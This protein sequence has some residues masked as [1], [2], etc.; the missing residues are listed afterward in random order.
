[1]SEEKN[2][3]QVTE[4]PV[5]EPAPKTSRKNIFPFAVG[6]AVLILLVLVVMG[7]LNSQKL[8]KEVV[9]V[10]RQVEA[11]K[12][13]G[14]KTDG[15]LQALTD[16]LAVRALQQRRNRIRRALRALDDLQPAVAANPALAAK[17]KGLRKALKKEGKKLAQEIGSGHPVAAFSRPCLSGQPCPPGPC[18]CPQAA[19]A[20][21]TRPAAPGHLECANGVCRLVPEKPAADKAYTVALPEGQPAHPAPAV[22]KPES[23]GSQAESSA[24]PAQPE[25][26]WTRFINLRIFGGN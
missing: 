22:A 12:E 25:T 11:L 24:S 4:S 15:R 16:E 26:W 5:S 17:V 13:N 21:K 14:R 8:H 19:A 18:P 23:A 6:L 2:E 1:M 3:K 9:V 10:E 20:R 7:F